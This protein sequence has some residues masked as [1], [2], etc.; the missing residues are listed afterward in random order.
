MKK[1]LTIFLAGILA[2]CTLSLLGCKDKKET[3]SKSDNIPETG[4]SWNP[5]WDLD[6]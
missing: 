5:E 4:T 3:S 2:V 6:E 1:V